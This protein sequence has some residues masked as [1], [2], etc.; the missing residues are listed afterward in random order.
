MVFSSSRSLFLPSR[1]GWVALFLGA[2]RMPHQGILNENPRNVAP[3]SFG[4][5]E[6]EGARNLSWAERGYEDGRGKPS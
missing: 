3:L 4:H 2:F 5:V 1:G 6:M